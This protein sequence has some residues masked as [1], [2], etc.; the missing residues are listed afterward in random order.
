MFWGRYND[1]YSFNLLIFPFSPT[2]SIENQFNRFY[3]VSCKSTKLSKVTII[4]KHRTSS[5]RR[6]TEPGSGILQ[7]FSAIRVN[8]FLQKTFNESEN[9]QTT[10][11]IT[12]L[13]KKS[14]ENPRMKWELKMFEVWHAFKKYHRLYQMTSQQLRT[15]S[16]AHLVSGKLEVWNYIKFHIIWYIIISYW[17]IYNMSFLL[18]KS[19]NH[20]ADNCL[21]PVFSMHNI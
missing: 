19:I 14:L 11:D 13:K 20:N 7:N 10:N 8:F 1:T 18:S 5:K 21:P 17:I 16:C 15:T 9:L 2:L 6:F 3:Q 12:S 4:Y